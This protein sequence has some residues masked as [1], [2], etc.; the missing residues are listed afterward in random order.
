MEHQ[1]GTDGEPTKRV[2]LSTRGTSSGQDTVKGDGKP[3]DEILSTGLPITHYLPI[4]L[5]YLRY[6]LLTHVPTRGTPSHKP[7]RFTTSPQSATPSI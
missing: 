4:V 5:P 2:D 7:G 1:G 3:T 6:R